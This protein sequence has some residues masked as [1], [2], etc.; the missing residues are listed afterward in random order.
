[1][2]QSISWRRG[3]HPKLAVGAEICYSPEMTESAKELR[4]L[5]LVLSAHARAL[6]KAAEAA[7]ERGV[8]W[9]EMA[10]TARETAAASRE[11]AG[12]ARKRQDAR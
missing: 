8:V 6:R 3:V 9:R 12:A 11:H 2:L 1:V 5:S 4:S 10:R 7:R